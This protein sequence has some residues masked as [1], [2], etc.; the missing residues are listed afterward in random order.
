MLAFALITAGSL[1]IG[2]SLY[3]ELHHRLIWE[4]YKAEYE[5]S[6]NPVMDKLREP[7]E[8]TYKANIYVLWPL[9]MIVGASAVFIGLLD[10]VQ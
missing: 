3:V 8:F 9:V 6:R 7:N 5:R 4:H 2:L 10:L 1:L